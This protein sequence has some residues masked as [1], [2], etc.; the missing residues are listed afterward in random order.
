MKIHVPVVIVSLHFTGGDLPG[1]GSVLGS[2]EFT[3]KETGTPCVF[4]VTRGDYSDLMALV[5]ENLTKA[6]VGGAEVVDQGLVCRGY[7]L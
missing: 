1:V 4:K 3:P 6:E 2:H 7:I 5:V